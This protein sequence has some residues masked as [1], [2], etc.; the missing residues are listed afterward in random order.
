VISRGPIN[1]L[2]NRGL[3]FIVPDGS[4]Y[5]IL[6]GADVQNTVNKVLYTGYSFTCLY[7]TNL[8]LTITTPHDRNLKY[9]NLYGCNPNMTSTTYIY[10]YNASITINTIVKYLPIHWQRQPEPWEQGHGGT[11]T[12][13]LGKCQKPK[14]ILSSAIHQLHHGKLYLNPIFSNIPLIFKFKLS[15]IPLIFKFQVSNLPPLS[16]PFIRVTPTPSRITLSYTSS[17]PS[18]MAI[19]IPPIFPQKRALTSRSFPY[20]LPYTH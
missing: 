13:Y 3:S 1:L 7:F 12:K 18:Q 11:L 9:T 10:D 14:I 20:S 16:N 17:F 4:T 6:S 2:S 8:S 19:L 5:P 15:N